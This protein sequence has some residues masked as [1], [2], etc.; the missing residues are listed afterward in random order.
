[1]PGSNIGKAFKLLAKKKPPR[2]T[3][4]ADRVA[5]ALSRL[6]DAEIALIEKSLSF[7]FPLIFFSRRPV[8]RDE[9]LDL[10]RACMLTQATLGRPR[11]PA[12]PGG[13]SLNPD[14]WHEEELKAYLDG[15]LLN[16]AGQEV[17]P[18]GVYL[19]PSF[20]VF[21]N[22]Q[23]RAHAIM[24]VREGKALCEAGLRAVRASPLGMES[25]SGELGQASLIRLW[26]GEVSNTQFR[27]I[28]DVLSGT[29]RGF[30]TQLIRLHYCGSGINFGEQFAEEGQLTWVNTKP[31]WG[32][33]SRRDQNQIDLGAKYFMPSKTT[34]PRT[35]EIPIIEKKSIPF[36]PTTQAASEGSNKNMYVSR[37]GALLHE[38]THL[39]G[40]TL[41]VE[42]PD[43]VYAG[44]GKPLP[45]EGVSR[46]KGYGPATCST[47]ARVDPSLAIKNADNYRL[48][49]EAAALPGN[50]GLA[51]G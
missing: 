17:R 10:R 18:P 46:E 50:Q 41:D 38:A 35:Q 23:E 6:S 26:F 29:L 2:G 49:C 20:W 16:E 25:K 21:A 45:A 22:A 30:E 14:S 9:L 40:E 48:F 42:V 47:L 33:A 31:E 28:F 7:G 24:G 43:S 27:Q 44:F 51:K 5:F 15:F 13:K 36:D 1:M 12:L 34:G 8:D 19:A 3:E 32:S 4:V 11:M 37:G 39:Y